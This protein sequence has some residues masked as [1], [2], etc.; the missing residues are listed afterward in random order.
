MRKTPCGGLA[1]PALI[2]LIGLLAAFVAPTAHAAATY[3]I[4]QVGDASWVSVT[5]SNGKEL[6]GLTTGANAYTVKATI[7]L[8]I[9]DIGALHEG[10][11]VRVG[12]TAADKS[13]FGPFLFTDTN[14][15]SFLV[16]KQGRNVFS[17]AYADSA[18][19]ALTRT[20]T[21]EQG[22]YTCDL[23]V[24]NILWNWY[25]EATSSTWRIGKSSTYTFASQQ[26][27]NSPCTW[28]NAGGLSPSVNGNRIDIGSWFLNCATMYAV[29]NKKDTSGFRKDSQVGWAHVVPE[30]GAVKNV[31]ISNHAIFILKAVDG[32][33]PGCVDART[34]WANLSRKDVDVST[35]RKAVENLPVGS[36]AAVRQSD[37]SW[38]LAYNVGSRLPGLSNSMKTSDSTDPVGLELQNNTG[39]IWQASQVNFFVHFQDESIP[40]RVRVEMQSTESAYQTTTLTTKPIEPPIGQGQSAIR[41]DPNGG[42]GDAF[43]KVGDPG[44]AATT[45]EAATFTRTGHTFAGWNTKADGSGTAYAAGAAIA[46]PAEGQVLT[47]YAQWKANTYKVEFKDW[48]GR[49]ITSGTADYGTTPTA[50]ALADATWL[51]DPDM[52]FDNVDG[53]NDGKEFV[54]D[55]KRQT[56]R[57]NKSIGA[58]R[59]V[60]AS[61]TVRADYDADYTQSKV[62]GIL[63]WYWWDADGQIAWSGYACQP[64]QTCK[65]SAYGTIRDAGTVAAFTQLDAWSDYG[66]A[67]VHRMQLTQVDPATHNGVARDGYVF[68]GWDKDI[69]KPITGDTVYTARYRPAVYRIRYDANGGT[70]TMADQ[71]HTYDRKQALTANAFTREGY[72][73]TGWNTRRDGQGK[74]FADKQT[75]ANLLA[76][77]D[78]VGVLYAQWERVPETAMPGTGGHVGRAPLIVGGIATAAALALA[79]I[80]RRRGGR[81][82]V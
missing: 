39:H 33:T 2:A 60:A 50:P 63:G 48:Q 12:A 40:N 70:G 10:D 28:N 55:G 23:T 44:T 4:T 56:S 20:G 59:Q 3:D 8:R 30:S 75:V 54:A 6:S 22:S 46:Y 57:D 14:L 77:E 81:H 76:H 9:D 36:F 11:V 17:V 71:K 26:S 49:T 16:D 53:W 32:R 1:L 62:K 38:D 13:H 45:P 29:A 24:D 78:A 74:A 79:V 41:Y 42:D 67:T 34:G 31:D 65:G 27:R 82:A 64:G 47:L 69:S 18:A 5:D 51:A 73:F 25:G 72:R 80:A 66:T 15:P 61:T 68:T 35:Y 21:E 19:F 43:R 37:G 52:N 7:R 58:K